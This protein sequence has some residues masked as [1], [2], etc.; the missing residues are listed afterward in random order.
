MDA[1]TLFGIGVVWPQKLQFGIWSPSK[2][3]FHAGR[4][5]GWA[6]MVAIEIALSI[7]ISFGACDSTVTFHSNNQGVIGAL[8]TGQSQNNQQNLVLQQII[9]AQHSHNIHIAIQYVSADLNHADGPLWGIAPP[10]LIAFD[11]SITLDNALACF[12]KPLSSTTP[13]TFYMP[14]QKL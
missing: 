8:C 2:K 1:S 14:V 12:V 9:E 11:T 4:D 6:E 7:V 10:K 13:Q 3:T 5:I